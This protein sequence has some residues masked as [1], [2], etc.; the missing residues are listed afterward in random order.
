[1]LF[2]FFVLHGIR[3]YTAGRFFFKPAAARIALPP[4]K[5]GPPMGQPRRTTTILYLAL[6]L[7]A[8]QLLRAGLLQLLFL[9]VPHT[10]AASDL[11]SMLLFFALSGLL[12]ALS[13]RRVPFR[14][15]PARAGALELGAAALFALLLVS[16]PLLAGG[17]NTAD[18]VQ[19][20]YGCIATPIF[21][22][23]L[24]RGLV[25]NALSRVFKSGWVL[26]SGLYPAVWPVAFGLC[27][28]PCVSGAYG[29]CRCFILESDG[30]PCIW[31]A[32]GG[33]AAVAQRLLF[34]HA[35]ARGAKRIWS[36]MLRAL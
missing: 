14:I 33:C 9:W 3:F 35:A 8:L 4:P 31:P 26:L 18:L 15:L 22:E 36:L 27:R 5:G 30:R 19:L 25:W 7:A 24:F 29:A 13:R 12:V 6:L 2:W 34:L 11:A 16:G 10:Y 23:L 28:Q 17:Y 1:M 21:E 20:V 32:A